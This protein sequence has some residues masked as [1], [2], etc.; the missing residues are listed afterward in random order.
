MAAIDRAKN[1]V[2]TVLERHGH[3][4]TRFTRTSVFSSIPDWK[5]TCKHAGRSSWSETCLG[6]FVGGLEGDLPARC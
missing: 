1:L 4:L 5:A 2:K 6:T 3:Q